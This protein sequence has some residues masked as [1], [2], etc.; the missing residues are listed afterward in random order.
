MLPNEDHVGALTGQRELVLNEPLNVGQPSGDQIRTQDGDAAFP[1]TAL[2]RGWPTSGP[3]CHL[4]SDEIGEVMLDG[5]KAADRL[6]IQRH[7]TEP[8][9]ARSV[10]CG[11]GHLLRRKP[12]GPQLH[13]RL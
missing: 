11:W 3:N 2:T 5:G 10:S 4:L 1:R 7:K 9:A 13:R 8:Q 12:V 6:A